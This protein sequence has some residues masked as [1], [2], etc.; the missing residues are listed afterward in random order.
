[1]DIGDVKLYV[2]NLFTLGFS[3]T[4]ISD[5]LSIMLLI[6]TIGF[7]ISRWYFLSKNN[8]KK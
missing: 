4:K 2:I 3:M 1:M 7:T 6:T 5:M 8:K